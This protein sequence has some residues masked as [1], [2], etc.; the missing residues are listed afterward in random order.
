M[1]TC[2][3]FF[4]VH[5]TGI[6]FY[7]QHTINKKKETDLRNTNWNYVTEAAKLGVHWWTLAMLQKLENS[8][9]QDNYYIHV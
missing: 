7:Y 3:F 6:R 2:D 9:I 4:S 5:L 8:V 1:S